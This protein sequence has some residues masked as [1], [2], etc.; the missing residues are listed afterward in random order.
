[1]GLITS[2]PLVRRST[3]TAH[4][5]PHA[6]APLRFTAEELLVSLFGRLATIGGE[7]STVVA[8]R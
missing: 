7:H 5:I 1:M 8:F 3:P 2:E 6:L 4:F